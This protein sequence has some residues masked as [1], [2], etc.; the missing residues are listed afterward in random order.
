MAPSGHRRNL[1]RRRNLPCR[2]RPGR[3]PRR[4]TNKIGRTQHQCS[5]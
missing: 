2:R 5:V 3:R 4:R 1:P